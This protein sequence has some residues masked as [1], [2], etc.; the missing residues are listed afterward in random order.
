MS[1]PPASVAPART[2]ILEASLDLFVKKGFAATSVGDIAQ[3]AGVVRATV[4][5]NFEDKE[6]ILAAI[7]GDYMAGYA[8]IAQ[9][10]RKRA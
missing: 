1:R 8:R 4:Y 3:A 9:T 10:L 7:I 5:N 6:D 2:R